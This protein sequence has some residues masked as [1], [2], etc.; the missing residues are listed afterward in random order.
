MRQKLTLKRLL[1]PLK[2]RLQVLPDSRQGRNKQYT[3]EDA[4]LSSLLK[5]F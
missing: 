2:E 3:M 4:E 1:S 5:V